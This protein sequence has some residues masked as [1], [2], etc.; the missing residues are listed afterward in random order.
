MS[1]ASF[2]STSF[3]SFIVLL[4]LEAH[5]NL[6]PIKGWDSG[7][8]GEKKGEYKWRETRAFGFVLLL[9]ARALSVL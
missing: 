5:F 4:L 3:T 6:V 7:R 1:T 2:E 8:E 9:G